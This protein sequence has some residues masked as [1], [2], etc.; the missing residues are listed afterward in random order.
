MKRLLAAVLLLTA[1]AKPETPA[2]AQGPAAPAVAGNAA[3][4]Q[5][6]ITR[7]GCTVCHVVPGIERGGVLGPS[8]VGL[9]ARPTL[10]E[11]TV[12]NTPRNVVQ[13]II[14]PSTL[15]PQTSMPAVGIDEPSARDIAA[16]LLNS[17]Q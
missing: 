14:N 5:V 13:Y 9:A 1:C 16:Y 10:G 3:N 11:G 8:L 2:P 7:Y 17:G 15:N 6:L 4:G 12:Q